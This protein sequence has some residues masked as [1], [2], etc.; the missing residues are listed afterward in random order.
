MRTNKKMRKLNKKLLYN[1]NWR[2]QINISNQL[3]NKNNN[4]PRIAIKIS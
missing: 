2:K 4:R 1:S 3:T